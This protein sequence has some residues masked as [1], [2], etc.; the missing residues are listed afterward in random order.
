M[1]K[2][3]I[4]IATRQSPLALLQVEELVREA[5]ITDYELIKI[6]S[7]GDKHTEQSLMDSTLA[8]D[9][10]TRELDEA[11]LTGKAD[12]PADQQY[13]RPAVETGLSDGVN[14]EIKSGLK[15]GDKVRG[16]QIITDDE[17]QNN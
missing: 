15:K 5:R 6:S 3:T 13:E 1:T 8:S 10:F 17:T 2:T 11:L 12:K 4:R 9:F 14:I 7:Y 16:P